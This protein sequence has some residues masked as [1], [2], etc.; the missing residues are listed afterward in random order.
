MKILVSKSFVTFIKYFYLKLQF[1]IYIYLFEYYN[2][3]PFLSQI[4]YSVSA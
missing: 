2:I 3:L 1:Q 4:F